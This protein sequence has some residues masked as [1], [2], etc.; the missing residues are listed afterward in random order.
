MRLLFFFFVVPILATV[1][2][3]EEAKSKLVEVWNNTYPVPFVKILPYNK[4]KFLRYRPKKEKVLYIYPF[5]VTISA[6]K[7][8]DF[9]EALTTNREFFVKLIYNPEKNDYTLSLDSFH[10]KFQK[11][12][13]NWIK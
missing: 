6:Y 12:K 10:E 1:P 3:Y 11:S 13:I 7:N 4:K 8:R 2:K 9:K 5:K